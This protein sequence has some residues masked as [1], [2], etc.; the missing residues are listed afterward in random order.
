M[1]G[2]PE[3]SRNT[4]TLCWRSSKMMSGRAMGGSVLVLET[5]CYQCPAF[6]QTL[7]CWSDS[8]R[9]A[10]KIHICIKIINKHVSFNIW[11]KDSWNDSSIF[12][13]LYQV[14]WLG[15]DCSSWQSDRQDQWYHRHCHFERLD[16][17]VVIGRKKKKLHN[18][19]K[20]QQQN[21]PCHACQ[22]RRQHL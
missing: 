11:E 9:G 15:Q 8:E 1:P 7:K 5:P 14:Y 16:Q 13:Y 22:V 12:C 18:F 2:A 20:Q 10:L 3:V 4:P 6:S 21:N 17:P 19:Q